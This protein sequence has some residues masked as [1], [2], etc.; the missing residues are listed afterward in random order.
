MVTDT[1]KVEPR[2]GKCLV[3]IAINHKTLSAQHLN[4]LLHAIHSRISENIFENRNW[5]LNMKS[6]ESSDGKQ[7]VN[8]IKTS[9]LKACW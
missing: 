8:S 4:P 1:G 9:S 5:D 7:K 2:G 3:T 6:W